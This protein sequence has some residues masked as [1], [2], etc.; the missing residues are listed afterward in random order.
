MS[1]AWCW[2]SLGM[3]LMMGVGWGSL[4]LM[5]GGGLRGWGW[6]P[7]D[8]WFMLETDISRFVIEF[9]YSILSRI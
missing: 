3:R 4:I 2:E 9:A 1:R 8:P 6:G 5:R 7:S